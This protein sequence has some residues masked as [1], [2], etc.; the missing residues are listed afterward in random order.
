MGSSALSGRWRRLPLA[1][2]AA[3]AV[4]A[5]CHRHEAWEPMLT[6]K[7]YVSDRFYDVEILGPKEALIVGYNGKLLQTADFGTTWNIVDSGSGNGLYS[8]SF[9]DDKKT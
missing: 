8:V 9:A 1:V 5:G 4:T 6:Q 2:L 7:V 3:T